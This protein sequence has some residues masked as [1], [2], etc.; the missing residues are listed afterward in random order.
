MAKLNLKAGDIAETDSE[1]EKLIEKLA[2]VEENKRQRLAAAKGKNSSKNERQLKLV[3]PKAPKAKKEKTPKAPVGPQYLSKDLNPRGKTLLTPELVVKVFAD[4]A[5][6]LKNPQIAEK[7]N[8][9]QGSVS[10]ILSG[11]QWFRE[12]MTRYGGEGWEY[13]KRAE[14]PTKE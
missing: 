3:E 2:K 12:R 10:T 1:N 5:T 11:P 6:D 8:I 4:K 14:R 13:P 7:Y 9:S